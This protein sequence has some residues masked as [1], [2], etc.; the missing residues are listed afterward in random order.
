M[1]LFFNLLLL[2]SLL[3]S[4]DSEP[5]TLDQNRAEATAVG[6]LEA[7]NAQDYETAQRYCTPAA[8]KAIMNFSTN[9]KMV[10]KEEKETLLKGLSITIDKINCKTI[11]GAT[12][13]TI[14]CG[15]EDSEAEFE[16]VEQDK[17]WFVKTEIGI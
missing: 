6:F 16:L 12:Y 4:C 15:A 7:L 5:A 9:L 8:A 17:K 13:C 1:K 14:C 11:E 2:V 10:S 3:I